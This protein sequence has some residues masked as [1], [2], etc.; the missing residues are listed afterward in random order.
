MVCKLK[1][2]TKQKMAACNMVS[3]KAGETT[4]EVKRSVEGHTVQYP[5]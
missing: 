4:N 3:I 5:H 2:L 1:E